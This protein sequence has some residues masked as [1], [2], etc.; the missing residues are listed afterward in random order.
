M[1]QRACQILNNNHLK[2]GPLVTVLND[3]GFLLGVL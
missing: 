2:L 3:P 1:Q